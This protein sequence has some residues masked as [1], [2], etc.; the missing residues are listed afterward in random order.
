VK[1]HS[2]QIGPST[3]QNPLLPERLQEAFNGYQ[4]TQALCTTAQLGLA[5]LIHHNGYKTGKELARQMGADE[6][7]LG[8]F[9]E[10]LLALGVVEKNQKNHFQLTEIGAL[11]R[12]DHPNCILGFVRSTA[13]AYPAWG[14]LG[15]SVQTGKAAFDQ[16]FQMSFYEYL[17]QNGGANNDFN[18]WMEES[19]TDWVLPALEAYPFSTFHHFVDIGGSTGGLTTA[20][21]TRY[22]NLQA[23]IFDQ[24]HVVTGAKK[25]LEPAG[26]AHRCTIMAGDF[27]ESIPAKGDLYIISRVL[28][29]W[30][31]DHALRILKNCRTAMDDSARLLII[32]FV[33]PNKDLT[34]SQLLSSLHL[35]V[36]GGNP[37]RTEDQYKT[38]LFQAGF[39]GFK[40][41]TPPGAISFMEVRPD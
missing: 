36:L 19:T 21:L 5:D 41:I 24:A 40:L 33:L 25:T 35:Q 31:D 38:L 39:K 3:A 6:I 34:V 11:L 30:D 7:I 26:V 9:M 13:L 20:I 17:A 4:L 23:T 2:S 37:M 22:P 27:F 10:L 29:N 8:Q 14:N 12:S 16:T 28:L 18:Q 15:H 1:S 32:D